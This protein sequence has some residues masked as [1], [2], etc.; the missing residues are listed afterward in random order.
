MADH[1]MIWEARYRDLERSFE[2]VMIQAAEALEQTQAALDRLRD[3]DRHGD[4]AIRSLHQ[5]PATAD[6]VVVCVADGAD[7][8]YRFRLLRAGTVLHDGGEQRQNSWRIP[9][10]FAG[11]AVRVDVVSRATAQRARLECWIEVAP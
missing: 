9:E 1:E 5:D 4:L 8:T 3:P 7:L 10:G 6:P 11:D 2:H